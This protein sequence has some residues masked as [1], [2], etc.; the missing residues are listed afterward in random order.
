M[1]YFIVCVICCFMNILLSHNTSRLVKSLSMRISMFERPLRGSTVRAEQSS[2]RTL[3]STHNGSLRKPTL[4]WLA[5]TV[6]TTKPDRQTIQQ[7]MRALRATKPQHASANSRNGGSSSVIDPFRVI[8]RAFRPRKT[9]DLSANI[10]SVS[11][12]DMSTTNNKMLLVFCDGTGQDGTLASETSG[13]DGGV[14]DATNVLRLSRGVLPWSKDGRRQIVFYQSGVGSEADFDGNALP[15]DLM[16]AALGTAVASKIRDCY[17]FIAQN[18]DEGDEICIF[19]FSR[20]AYTAR[21]LAG[22]IDKIGLLQREK[23]GF[24][25]EIWKSLVDGETPDIPDG[26]RQTRIRCVGVW[27]TVGSVFNTI[28]A[29][30][31]KDTD[32]PA[33]IDCALHAMALQENRQR[34]LPTLWTVPSRGLFSP[35]SGNPQVLKQ[36]WFPGA[37]SNVGGGYERHEL[38]DL[39]LFWMAG[40]IQAFIN[41]DLDFIQ[42]SGQVKPEPWGTSQPNNAYEDLPLAQKIIIGH[43]TRLESGQILKD[44]TFH[45]SIAVAPTTLDKPTYMITLDSLKK[46]FG[47]EWTPKYSTLNSFEQTCKDH[48]GKP[49]VSSLLFCSTVGILY[50]CSSYCAIAQRNTFRYWEVR[51]ACESLWSKALIGAYC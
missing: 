35:A 7:D 51:V 34:F 47:V 45:P 28:D 29:L 9:A 41:L 18:F 17:A 27:D 14:Q 2:G 8:A 50:S 25:F 37:H 26:T 44:A 12:P 16:I 11:F 48:W 1:K 31:I 33:S 43:E 10:P 30:S 19:G 46:A 22:L 15:E 32:L 3:W 49:L 24:F 5:S 39:A 21:K 4:Q 23:L 20:G 38:S 42:H 13:N 6:S 36:I 40:E